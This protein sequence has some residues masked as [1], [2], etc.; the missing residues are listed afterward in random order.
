MLAAGQS[1]WGW[2]LGTVCDWAT[3]VWADGMAGY[4]GFIRAQF[5]VLVFLYRLISFFGVPG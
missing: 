4:N 5:C 1:L 2:V 3:W